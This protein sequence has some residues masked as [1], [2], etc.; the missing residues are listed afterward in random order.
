M[1]S[2]I[3]KIALYGHGGLIAQQGH[4]SLNTNLCKNEAFRS[5][6]QR[7]FDIFDFILLAKCNIVVLH[8]L[9]TIVSW[10]RRPIKQ[11]TVF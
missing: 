6:I 10:S 5:I 4:I 2:C 7:S 1:S 8:Y 9:T 3:C 11:L